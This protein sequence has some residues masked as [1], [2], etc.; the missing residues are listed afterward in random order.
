M[1]DCISKVMLHT[2]VSCWQP[3]L[4]LA[5][6]LVF[7]GSALGCPARCECSAQSKSVI[8][9]RKRLL[10][11]PEGIPIETRVLDLSKN[12]LRSVNPD[13]FSSFPQLEELDLS[14]NII[15]SVEPGAF[16]ALVNMHSLSLKSN[17]IKLIPLG[18][19]TGLANLTILDIS[20]NKIV[21][22]LDY[23]FQDLHNLKV[24]E[25]G[26]NDLVYISHRAFS[27]LLGLESL[28]LE[29][30]NLTMVP[31]EALSHLHNLVSL[32]LRQ[33]NIALLHPNSFR[34]LFRLRHLEIDSWP[35]LDS[36]P[37]D[38]LQGL[39]LT[40]LSVTN[41]NLS[42]FPHQAFRHLP[43][44][45]HLN[46]SFCRMSH[47]LGGAM[48]ELGRLQELHLVGSGL[49]TIEPYAFQGLRSL[50]VLNI[51]H[52]Q[53]DTLERSAFQAPEVLEKLLIDGN[54]LVCD[55]RLMW[56]LQRR[57]SLQFGEAQPECSTPEGV[58]GRPFREFKESLLSYYVT[59]TK[60]R[61]RQ[62]KT[63]LLFVDE[64][65][66]ARLFCSADGTPRPAVT[67][68]TPRQRHITNKNSG[69]VTVHASGTLEIKVSEVHDSGVYMC[70]AS[71][72]AGNDSLSASLAVKSLGISDRSLYANRT[73]Q[74]YTEPN[75]TATNGTNLFNM[76][77]GL[78][79]KTILVS[80]AMGCF[81]FL[82]VVL[83]CFLLLFVWSRGKGKHKSNI[84]IEYVPRKSAGTGAEGSEQAGPRRVNMKMI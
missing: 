20:D 76:T 27:G 41:T 65:Q 81:T 33:L 39:N 78:D 26:D 35:A 2:A 31:T 45:T 28:T 34:K 17:R 74:F 70:V 19:F 72:A 30:C 54:P 25:V 12:K 82:G 14:D 53:L 24:L 80:T 46:L 43:Y 77:F 60:P 42:S 71:N 13:N 10:T 64:G 51:S 44:L 55:C 83:F 66:P 47:I 68:L 49:L 56:L 16:N 1:V 36:F 4:G 15:G 5:L 23:M 61:I 22:L 59:C 18:V 38:T 50:R 84:D 62:N 8:C 7:V 3:I 21:I 32:R 58:R 37:T 6:I 48:A 9:H 57:H 75:N 11:I 63:Q 69:R 67:W 52:N 29:R 79:L 40:T 73:S